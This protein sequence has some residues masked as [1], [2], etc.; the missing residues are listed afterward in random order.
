MFCYEAAA[1]IAEF[2]KRTYTLYDSIDNVQFWIVPDK[3]P[4]L[5][6]RVGVDGHCFVELVDK[7]IQDLGEPPLAIAQVMCP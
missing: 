7:V 4:P 5:M 2:N 6:I 1:I 3:A